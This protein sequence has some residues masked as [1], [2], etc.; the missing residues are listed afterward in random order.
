MRFITFAVMAL[1]TMPMM[2]QNEEG[3]NDID[4]YN[5]NGSYAPRLT[6]SGYGEFGGSARNYTGSRFLTEK[7][8]DTENSLVFTIP[9]IGFNIDYF[10]NKN[11]SLS[12]KAEYL[13]NSGIRLDKLTL[14]YAFRPE[15]HATGGIFTLPIGYGNTDFRFS[16]NF[17]IGRP[18]GE[19]A[20]MP[21]PFTECGVSLSGRF[22]FGLDYQASV[23]T[24]VDAT[25]FTS[26][27]FV[28]ES[29]Q[30]FTKNE[31]NFISPAA[32]LRLGY[33][34]FKGL[35]VGAGIYYCPNTARNMATYTSFKSFFNPERKV[36]LT[37]YYA[38]LEYIHQWFTIRGS[39]LEGNMGNSYFLTNYFSE[40]IKDSIAGDIKYDGGNIAKLA[41]TYMGE[42]GINVKNILYPE[43]DGPDIIP[44]FHYEYYNS[45][46]KGQASSVKMDPRG[47]V[48]MMSFG[49][50]WRPT[51]GVMLKCN[52][53]T[54]KIGDG[55]SAGLLN[56]NEINLG[57]AY[58]FSL[59]EL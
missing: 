26:Q 36:P 35:K 44:F 18:E 13:S 4:L 34:G 50:N 21:M 14:D 31:G 45:Q 53:T 51:D 10:V 38:D 24:G 28:K 11:I 16:E 52:Y 55:P 48:R 5:D 56:M 2:A 25:Y 40:L 54:R 37:I 42:I 3:D 8:P 22:A 23:T 12:G 43:T 47:K 15:F 59:L 6:I 49:V 46:E 19:S 58:D 20:I 32:T 41:R 57:L 30:G 1:F 39:F 9:A 33:S 27:S 29:H 7:G 17:T